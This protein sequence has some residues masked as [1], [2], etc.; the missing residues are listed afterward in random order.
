MLRFTE[1]ALGHV[2]APSCRRCGSDG[3]V[4]YRDADAIC[5]DI[6][7]ATLNEEPGPGPNIAL[8]GVEPLGHVALHE[9]LAC[10]VRAGA[11]RLRL[12][13]DASALANPGVASDLVR[14]GVSHLQFELLGS[15]A[16]R[17]D[18]L[19]RSESPF[20][21]TLRGI[22]CFVESAAA[23][24]VR[25][26]VSARVPTCRHNLEDLPAIVTTATQAG[27]RHVR[28]V[29]EDGGLDPWVAAPW[30]EAACDTG[31][32]YATWVEVEGVPYGAAAGWEL[33]LACV[34]R[35]IRGR[36]SASCSNCPLD[37]VCGGTTPRAKDAILSR[38]SPP[39]EAAD[40][41]KAIH[42]SLSP[43]VIRHG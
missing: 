32:V 25:A 19:T 12:D 26:F 35:P 23:L 41:A 38:M 16:S 8:G 29:I 36:K 3:G 24:G 13:T 10:A 28:L 33:H 17:H 40:L 11:R 31:I 34:Y 14:A 4:S 18:A 5:A 43:P 27:A 9:I 15:T 1:I 2:D 6:A 7:H 20:D 39:S 30:L 21:D 42:K 37:D 22:A